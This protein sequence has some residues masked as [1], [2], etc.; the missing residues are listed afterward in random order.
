MVNH[1]KRSRTDGGKITKHKA[2]GGGWQIY[3]GGRPTNLFI[4]KGDPARWG[5]RQ[6][7]LLVD[8]D[9]FLFEAP[10][11]SVLM[12]RLERIRDRLGV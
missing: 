9:D 6:D 1:P 2:E 3:V 7:Y 11:V 12:M 10:G 4:I 8:E 5:D